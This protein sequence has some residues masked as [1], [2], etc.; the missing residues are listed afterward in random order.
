MLAGTLLITVGWA[1]V[2]LG[3]SPDWLP[4]LRV[5]IAVAGAAA[6]GLILAS[7]GRRASWGA[8]TRGAATLAI[9]PAALALIAGL[10]GPLAYSIDTAATAHGGSIPTAG[11]AVAGSAGGRAARAA[12]RPRRRGQIR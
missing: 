8:R 4:W 9:A 5:V 1:W 2:L 7:P 11:P 12:R 10:A 3:R 6:A